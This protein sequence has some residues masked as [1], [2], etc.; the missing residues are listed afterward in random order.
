M[1]IRTNGS[2]ASCNYSIMG[3]NTATVENSKTIPIYSDGSNLT[4]YSFEG[5][6]SQDSTPTPTVPVEVEEFGDK[7]VNLYNDST[8]TDGY[9]IYWNNGNPYPDA[10]AATSDYIPVTPGT[11]Y[12]LSAAIYIAGY[13]S[14]K[15]FLGTW[16]SS[17]S[18]WSK[19]GGNL[20]SSITPTNDCYYLKLIA[21]NK[22]TLHNNFMLNEGSTVLPYEPYGKYKIPITSAG[23]TQNI[24][25]SEPLRKIGDYADTVD[26]EGVVTRKIKKLVLNGTE[27][28]NV[29]SVTG[30]TRFNRYISG[31]TDKRGLCSHYKWLAQTGGTNHYYSSTNYLFIFSETLATEADFKSWLAAQ[32]AAGT[33]VTVYYV[34]ATPT[35]ES[36]TAPTI[37]TSSGFSNIEIG[38][39]LA[40]SKFTYDLG[41]MFMPQEEKV[42][43]NGEWV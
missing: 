41:K 32:Y 13:D 19:T 33:P 18:S 15:T 12:S 43:V 37:P 27:S 22:A 40:P 21:Y 39:S 4:D 34:L 10:N 6:C 14:N 23:Q 26:S 31:I 35:T 20:N 5:Q 3:Q 7:T 24:I 29:T 2:W 36:V 30:A 16:S 28:W 25:L 1:Q 9:H 11:T 42:R 17:S 8:T 38:T